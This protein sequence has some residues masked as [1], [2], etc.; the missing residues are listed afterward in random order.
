MCLCL[1]I[2]ITLF[3]IVILANIH[4][5]E[6][7]FSS[8]IRISSTNAPLFI[9]SKI[10]FTDDAAPV[11]GKSPRG[12][13]DERC[14]ETGC[15]NDRSGR[16]IK[17]FVLGQGCGRYFSSRKVKLILNKFN[18]LGIFKKPTSISLIILI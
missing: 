5:Y 2:V 3:G 15:G 13:N 16:K 12:R 18:L 6:S 8:H 9:Y 14:T 1:Y 7:N 11:S 4:P 17:I 10:Y